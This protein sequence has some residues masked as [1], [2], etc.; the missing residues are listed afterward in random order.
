MKVDLRLL[1]FGSVSPE[2]KLSLLL[3]QRF[4]SKSVWSFSTLIFQ[5]FKPNKTR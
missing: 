5:N 4:V 1:S 3:G 2:E